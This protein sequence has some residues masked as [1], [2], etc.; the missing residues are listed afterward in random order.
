VGQAEG[1][2]GSW[3]AHTILVLSSI[4]VGG[5]EAGGAPKPASGG[6]AISKVASEVMARRERDFFIMLLEEIVGKILWNVLLEIFRG[7]IFRGVEV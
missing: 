5:G 3:L 6:F 2:V 7:R 4:K 1:A